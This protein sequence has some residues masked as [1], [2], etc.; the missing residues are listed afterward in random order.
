M[1][2]IDRQELNAAA[3]QDM[4]SSHSDFH[5]SISKKTGDRMKLS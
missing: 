2:G 1:A 3:G 4:F 5:F